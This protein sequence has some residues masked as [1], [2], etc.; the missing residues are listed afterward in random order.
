MCLE[1]YSHPEKV[2]EFF[3]TDKLSKIYTRMGARVIM[4]DINWGVFCTISSYKIP[5][6][7]Y[8][9]A[10]QRLIFVLTLLLE[11]KFKFTPL[12]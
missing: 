8:T 1:A 2:K 4:K 7:M 9:D 3:G 5:L 12:F 6:P 11:Y 10:C